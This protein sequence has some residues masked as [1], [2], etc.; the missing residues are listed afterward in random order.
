MMFRWRTGATPK[1]SPLA[2]TLFRAPP[3]VAAVPGRGFATR[4]VFSAHTMWLRKLTC[5]MSRLEAGA[6]CAA[7][8]DPYDVAI[9]VH[10]GRV[11]TLSR[12]AGAGA[13][14]Y[15]SAGELH[16]MRNIGNDPEHYIVFEFHGR[17][18]PHVATR[19]ADQIPGNRVPAQSV[20]G[21]A[22]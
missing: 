2:A 1:P 7:H 11:R 8:A 21:P 16:G 13:L 5:H 6:G 9:L 4:P 14:I 22:A 19:A 17:P 10:S 20:A 12:E 15:C 3:P 18:L